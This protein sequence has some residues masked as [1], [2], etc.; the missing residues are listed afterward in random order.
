MKTAI[1]RAAVALLLLAA[2]VHV[3]PAPWGGRLAAVAFALT[4]SILLA[5]GIG[6]MAGRGEVGV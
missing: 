5:L 2:A 3:L 6:A 4:M 1:I